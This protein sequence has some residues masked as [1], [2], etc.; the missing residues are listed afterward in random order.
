MKIILGE[1][2]ND[3]ER[4]L[5][6]LLNLIKRTDDLPIRSEGTRI[7]VNLVKNM[8]VEN[9]HAVLGKILLLYSYHLF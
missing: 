9:P 4:P 1:N 2:K 7:L 5:T 3:A 8:W 6:R